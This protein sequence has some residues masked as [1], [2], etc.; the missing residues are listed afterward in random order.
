MTIK[1]VDVCSVFT[2]ESRLMVE[3]IVCNNTSRIRGREDNSDGCSWPSQATMKDIGQL[4]STLVTHGLCTR[5]P[6]L[7]DFESDV[8]HE[9]E[10]ALRRVGAVTVCY[11]AAFSDLSIEPDPKSLTN[12]SSDYR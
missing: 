5:I 10:A 2:E 7:P 11:E 3:L 4:H 1:S 12:S 6:D 9:A 8:D